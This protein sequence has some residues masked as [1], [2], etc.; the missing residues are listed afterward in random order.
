MKTGN[1]ENGPP[2]IRKIHKRGTETDPMRGRFETAING[3][4]AVVEYEPD[5]DLR[6][7]EQIALQEEGGIKAFLRRE[8]LP[9]AADALYQPDC[10][11]IGC[12]ISVMRYFYKPKPMRRLE[13]IRADIL[14]LER[15]TTGLLDEI[16]GSVR[17]S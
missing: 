1:G 8:V 6:D 2:V 16:L 9:Y 4:R 7:T 13:G 12:E 17:G 14:A 5:T 10:V 15:Q 3:K 11:K